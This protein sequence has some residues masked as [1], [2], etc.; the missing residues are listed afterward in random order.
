MNRT[1]RITAAALALAAA[2]LAG[3]DL[4]EVDDQPNPN[5]ISLEDILDNPTDAIIAN[6]A[7][8][9]EAQSRVRLETYLS[10]VG[11]LGREYWRVSPSD[12]RFT[13]DLLGKGS[14]VLD[15][16]TFYITAPW[17]A[18]YTAIRNANTLLQ[19]LSLNETLSEEE[20]A[21]Y[22]GFANTWKAY[23]YL[24]NLNL[25]YTNGIRFIQEGEDFA[26]PITDY[27]ASLDQIA[28]LLDDAAEDVQNGDLPATT[29]GADF[30][31][32]NRALAS[33]VDLYREDWGG[34][35]DAIEQGG[36]FE[37][38]SNLD[39]L[40]AGAYHIFGQG[41]GD[42]TNA[43]SFPISQGGDAT[44]AHPSFL[45]DIDSS[46]A[47]ID[48]VAPRLDDDGELAPRTFDELTSAYGVNVYP[49]P[50]SPI[51]IITN[52]EL[53]LN[54]AEARVQGTDT[55]GAIEDLNVV[56]NAARLGDY[57]GDTD[58]ASLIDELL[59]QRR[60]QLYAEGHRWVDVRRYDRL[61]ELPID[62]EERTD[63]DG[64]VIEADDVFE[65]FPV[66]Q[67]ENVGG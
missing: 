42:Q 58:D 37:A 6:L 67:N 30:Y 12:P 46:D 35:E 32:F 7:V 25:T 40:E 14:S 33:R 19:A 29:I 10:S 45:A 44:L 53:Y 47:R 50:L 11:V 57:D 27:D 5:G 18:R 64:N 20:R 43:F 26:G 49:S 39:P 62:R 2:P 55:D 9:T 8:G 24:L 1:F 52:G 36:F 13:T 63:D 22:R 48:K 61:S 15:D 51:P 38:V 66:P 54:R 16:N 17:G 28:E 3:C 59:Y 34:V 23:Q 60:Y 31:A 56:R 21:G 4:F 41:P 65:Q